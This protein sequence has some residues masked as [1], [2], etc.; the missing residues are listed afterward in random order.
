MELRKAACRQGEPRLKVPRGRVPSQR[1]A[2]AAAFLR[3]PIIRN[4]HRA[5]NRKRAAA[6]AAQTVTGAGFTAAESSNEA[7]SGW[8]RAGAQ[9]Q[10][11]ARQRRADV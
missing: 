3:R 8:G 6:A 5:R 11:P 2:G 4:V 9:G 1:R 7:G 10:L